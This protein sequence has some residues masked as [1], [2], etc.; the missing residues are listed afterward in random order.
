MKKS[1]I[2]ASCGLGP[3]NNL[4]SGPGNAPNKTSSMFGLQLKRP[5]SGPTQTHTH[6]HAQPP[7]KKPKLGYLKDMSAAE[8]G[9]YA[10]L[11]E[12][13]FFDKVRNFQHSFKALS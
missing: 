13:A 7:V 1:N 6:S 9:K 12:Y 5:H 2:K 3:G 4:V 8:A 11:A 10:T